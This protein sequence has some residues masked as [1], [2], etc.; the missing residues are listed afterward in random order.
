M[1]FRPDSK[2]E[3]KLEYYY[4]VYLFETVDEAQRILT[5]M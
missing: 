4:I 2:S 1:K 5:D 3:H